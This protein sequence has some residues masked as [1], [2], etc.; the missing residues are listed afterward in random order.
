MREAGA[1]R[2]G[3][4]VACFPGCAR[5]TGGSHVLTTHDPAQRF[6]GA[7]RKAARMRMGKRENSAAKGIIK[8]EGP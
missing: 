5:P 1:P 8:A 3:E 7:K 4:V 6:K 2:T